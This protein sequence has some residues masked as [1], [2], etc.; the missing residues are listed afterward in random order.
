MAS[1]HSLLEKINS[2]ETTEATKMLFR[3][4][5]EVMCPLPLDNIMI[6]GGRS[7]ETL[8][9]S[10]CNTLGK[11]RAHVRIADFSNTEINVKLETSVRGKDIFIVQTGAGFDGRSVNDHLM[12]LFLL[13]DA[14][15]RSSAKSITVITPFFPYCRADK[16]DHRGPISSKTIMDFICHTANR[17]VCIDLHASQTQASASIPCDNLYCIKLLCAYIK[18]TLFKDITNPNDNFVLVAPDAGAEKKIRACSDI[19]KITCSILTKQ[20]DYSVENS[21]LQSHLTGDPRL[22]VNKTAILVDD[23]VDTMGTM[24]Q[25][26]AELK[27]HGIKDAIV[28]ASHGVLSGPAIERIN[29][30]DDILHVIVTNSIPQE[31]N[32]QRCSKLIVLDLG[33]YLA[34]VVRRLM[35]GES[36]SELFDDKTH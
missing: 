9:D 13:Q 35:T 21:V 28:I 14:C 27:K 3:E 34:E 17:I 16:R 6:I 11:S 32:L 12:E 23:M 25:G 26:I 8:T 18:N 31:E 15:S 33:P 5:V 10:I 1:K 19:L 22:I 36:I 29:A 4:L 24:I 7:C 30:C 20:R 2:S